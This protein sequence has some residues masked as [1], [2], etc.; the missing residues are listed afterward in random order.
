MLKKYIIIYIL[1]VQSFANGFM[2]LNSAT[3]NYTQVFFKWPQIENAEYY[4]LAIQNNI[5][6][7]FEDVTTSNSFI[8]DEFNPSIIEPF[9]FNFIC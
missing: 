2:P 3:I 8:I 9:E 7:S 5:S 4:T 1:F 6:E